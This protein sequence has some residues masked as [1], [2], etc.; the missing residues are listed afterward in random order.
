MNPILSIWK[1]RVL[2]LLKLY[3]KFIS[4]QIDGTILIYSL[5]LIGALGFYSRE[6]ILE[7]ISYMPTG[8]VTILLKIVLALTL[9]GGNLTGYL[10]LADQVFLSPLNVGGKNF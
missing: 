10:K 2:Y 7:I 9:I 5:G 6:I 3:Y 4:F 1:K 8:Y